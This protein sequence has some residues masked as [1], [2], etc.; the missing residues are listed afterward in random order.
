MKKIRKQIQEEIFEC[1]QAC[2]NGDFRDVYEL[3][4][5]LKELQKRKLFLSD[6]EMDK[7]WKK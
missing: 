1:L 7:K 4:L 3:E 6:K 2:Y 5:I